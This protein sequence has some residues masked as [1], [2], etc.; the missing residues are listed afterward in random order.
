MGDITGPQREGLVFKQT[1]G[2]MT[3]KAVSNKY[4]LGEK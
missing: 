3:F 1:N 2:G 4:L